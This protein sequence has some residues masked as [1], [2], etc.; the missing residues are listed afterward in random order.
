MLCNNISA[1]IKSDSIEKNS[2]IDWATIELATGAE[3]RKRWQQTLEGMMA[4]RHHPY[5][6]Q[7]D[8][9]PCV[10][11]IETARLLDYG[12]EGEVVFFIPSLINR[13]YVLDLMEEQSLLRWLVAQ[14]FHIYVVD[15]GQSLPHMN[16]DACIL[17][18]LKPMLD[19]LNNHHGGRLVNIAGYCMGGVLSLALAQL[20][21]QQI[22]KMALLATP[23][24]FKPTMAAESSVCLYRMAALFY[25]FHR[26]IIK[27]LGYVP[28]DI[29]QMMFASS[30][31]FAIW[32]KFR[33]FAEIDS[34]SEEA[35]AF[36]ALEDW[37]NDGVS[38]PL[39]VAEVTFYDWFGENITVKGQWRVND[40]V[41]NPAAI[42]Q[43]CLIQV[44]DKDKIVLPASSLA[45]AQ[46]MPKGELHH[47]GLGHIG[48]VTS[49][50]AP[51]LAWQK[52]A[53]WFA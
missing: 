11:Q 46:L 4:Y 48:L 15:W 25:S 45:L 9:K 22:K 6:R 18:I 30:D 51:E 38:L 31:L 10:L 42:E 2:S 12:G 29:L 19:F 49:R 27:E 35:K 7:L 13:Y 24:D 39:S 21:P 8:E 44:A 14:G 41:I 34:T 16:L 23:W 50:R 53:Q 47:V 5:R 1:N 32:R 33:H 20:F 52:L 40:V 28:I 43:P 37:L 26:P 3:V 36:V 17:G